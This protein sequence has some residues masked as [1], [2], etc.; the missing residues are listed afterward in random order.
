M[1]TSLR[2]SIRRERPDGALITTTLGTTVATIVYPS[3][4]C[5]LSSDGDYTVV[6]SDGGE[7]PGSYRIE[8]NVP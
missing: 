1:S 3:G 6:V 5:Q 2:R 7:Q 8:L 4:T